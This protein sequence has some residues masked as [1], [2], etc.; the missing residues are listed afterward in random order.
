[1]YSMKN[2]T[3]LCMCGNIFKRTGYYMNEIKFH[4]VK[5]GFIM[6]LHFID[7]IDSHQFCRFI[8]KTLGILTVLNENNSIL[9]VYYKIIAFSC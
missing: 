5:F 9:T 8:M 7:K 3:H 2:Y 4:H 1:M 6:L